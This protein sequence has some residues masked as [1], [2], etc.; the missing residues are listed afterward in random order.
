MFV[1][2]FFLSHRYLQ[3]VCQGYNGAAVGKGRQ[4]AKTELEKLKLPELSTREAVIEA[5]RMCVFNF[6]SC[7]RVSHKYCHH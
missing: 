1:S 7:C 4:L 5:A 2:R 3:L 6:R